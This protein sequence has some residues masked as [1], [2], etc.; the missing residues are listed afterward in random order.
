[1]EEGIK[2]ILIRGVN[3]IGDAVLTTPAIRAIRKTFRDSHI[4]LLVKPRVAELFEENPDINE[5]ILYEDRFNTIIG[6]LKLAKILRTKRFDMAILLQNAF[7]A[8]LIAWLS[9]IPNRIGYDRDFRGFLLTKAIPVKTVKS[10]ELRVKSLE[11]QNI[12]KQH[13]VYYY[14]NL[15]KEALNIESD[16]I[17]LFIYPQKNEIYDARR[18]LNSKLK[19][20][21][22]KLVIGINPGATYGPAKRW[23]PKKFAELIKRIIDELNGGV[24]I[25]GSKQEVEIANEIS[26][27]I[28]P[29]CPPLSKG[30]GGDLNLL[31]MVGKTTLRQLSALISQCDAFITNDSGPMH[32]ASAIFVP[33]VA[34]FGSTDPKATGPL[35]KGHRVIYKEL[36]CSPCL[37]SECPERH[38]KCME[39]ITVDDIFGALKS[40]LPKEKAVFLDRDGTIIEDVRYLNSFDNLKILPEVA[41]GLPRLKS[42]G[43]KLIGITNQSGIARGIISEEFVRESNAYLQKTL[44]IDAFYYCPHHPDD[45][46]LCRKPETMLLQKARLEYGIDLKASYVI[47]DKESDVLLAK[48]LGAKG[49]LLATGEDLNLEGS[50]IQGF[51]GSSITAQ[52]K[53]IADFVAK[54]FKE[55]IEWIL[56]RRVE[57]PTNHLPC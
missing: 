48:Q 21:N 8:A 9:G 37:K 15:L 38:L 19:T 57:S 44:G 20:Q 39:E 43:F 34:I 17:E 26:S 24:V 31:N 12:P 4:T 11:N 54:D 28:I 49:I 13:H 16:D 6:K 52:D 42:A 29:A 2:K 7:D 50:R 14:L 56:S 18:L 3:W 1:M 36:P 33:Q 45:N 55:A 25:F 53:E 35:G 32:I 47:G 5:I 30:G 41:E 27:Q 22:S 40:I 23:R 10:L 51:K 46:C